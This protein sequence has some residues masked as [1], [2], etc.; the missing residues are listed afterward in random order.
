MNNGRFSAVPADRLGPEMETFLVFVTDWH[1]LLKG[2]VQL[3]QQRRAK[4]RQRRNQQGS[5]VRHARYSAMTMPSKNA[6]KSAN[7]QPTRTF[8]SCF[9][10]IVSHTW[11]AKTK[12]LHAEIS[13]MKPLNQN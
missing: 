8:V 10:D 3:R 6:Q 7:F 11:T 5:L 13:G 9:T 4:Q 1:A 2:G 12:R